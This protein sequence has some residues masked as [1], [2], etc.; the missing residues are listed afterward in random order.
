MQLARV[1]VADGKI[2]LQ[3]VRFNLGDEIEIEDRGP[4]VK[5]VRRQLTNKKG[6]FEVVEYWELVGI[7]HLTSGAVRAAEGIASLTI[8]SKEALQ[9]W[10]AV[11][12]HGI[13]GKAGKPKEV[14]NNKQPGGIVVAKE[15]KTY[16][17]EQTK[18]I[19]LRDYI[20]TE[21]VFRGTRVP[22]VSLFEHLESDCPLDEFLENF[23]SVS[24]EAAVAV[25]LGAQALTLERASR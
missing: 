11:N 24:R 5:V 19:E 20:V 25:I 6:S 10:F 7:N 15:M 17:N 22:I 18:H 8:E 3:A 1:N 13:V 2:L 14:L 9:A 4:N 23:P 16:A 21:P 12:W